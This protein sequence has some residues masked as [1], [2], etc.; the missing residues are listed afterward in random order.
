M[1]STRAKYASFGVEKSPGVV[2]GGSGNLPLKFGIKAANG[3]AIPD[4]EAN[5]VVGRV[6]L[7]WR[8]QGSAGTWESK[9]GLATYDA[10]S[11]TFQINLKTTSLGM[12]KGT[13]YVV[14]VRVLANGSD[15][16]PAA[17]D[18]VGG[19][20]DLGRTTLLVKAEK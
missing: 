12:K 20:F 9:L 18:S 13:I 8:A 2:N 11:D 17:Y 1:R 16:K 5:G 3:T 6:Q 15:P 7:R 10:S 4:A 14:E 19:Q